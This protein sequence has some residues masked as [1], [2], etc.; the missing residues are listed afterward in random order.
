[1]GS[2]T[3]VTKEV[4]DVIV[5]D[6]NF[7]TIVIAIKEGRTIYQNIKISKFNPKVESRYEEIDADAGN[8]V[9]TYSAPF[10][11]TISNNGVLQSARQASISVKVFHSF[12]GAVYGIGA[13][14]ETIYQ[15]ISFTIPALTNTGSEL[16]IV[17]SQYGS[18][19]SYTL[20]GWALLDDNGNVVGSYHDGEIEI[21]QVAVG[22]SDNNVLYS[23]GSICPNVPEGTSEYTTYVLG[24]DNHVWKGLRVETS[25]SVGS[26]RR[27]KI[28]LWNFQSVMIAFLIS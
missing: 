15:T 10:T 4:S 18:S 14:E 12:S 20:Q 21:S 1:M 3:D 23:L 8:Y 17:L 26:D 25:P 24:D 16:G 19:H 11:W 27:I 13:Y 5:S 2:G 28:I 6:N 9:Y 7:S 22:A